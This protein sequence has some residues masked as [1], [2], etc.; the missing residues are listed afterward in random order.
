MEVVVGLEQHV[1]EL[2]V[3]DALLGALE[4]GL[5]GLLGDHLV[6]GE[7]L[8][9]VAEEVDEAVAAEPLGVVEQQALGLA[10]RRRQVEEAA[11]AGPG[12][13]R[14]WP[15]S[16]SAESRGRSS[17]LPP[18]SPIRP[19][20]A[21][22]EQDR[23]MAG[24]LQ[25]AQGEDA[26]QVAD[27]QAVG[28][29][30]EAGVGGRRPGVEQRP[31]RFVAHLV[32]EAAKREILR[33][34]RHLKA[35]HGHGSATSGRADGSTR[36]RGRLRPRARLW[37]ATFAF[38]S[39]R[40]TTTA[41]PRLAGMGERRVELRREPR[42]RTPTSIVSHPA[43]RAR[44]AT[45]TV[46]GVPKSLSKLASSSSE[47]CGRNE[48]MPPPPLSSTTSTAG[49]VGLPPARARARS[50]RAGRRGRRAGRR[51]GRPCPAAAAAT[52]SVVE[53]TPSI[54]LAPRF[55]STRG[56]SEPWR[57]EPL[58]VAHRHRGRG[59]DRSSPG[60][61]Q[62]N[63]A[64]ATPG[65][66]ASRWRAS[67]P[68]IACWA[69]ASASAH[70]GRP[71]R[72]APRQAERPRRRP[73]SGSRASMRASID[74]VRI[75]RHDDV[76][77][78][79]GVPPGP[80]GVDEHWYGPGR[81]A[82]G[83]PVRHHLRR[84]GLAEAQDDLGHV[85]AREAARRARGRRRR[86]R[87]GAPALA[88]DPRSRPRVGEDR[89]AERWR[90]GA[91]RSRDV[92]APAPAT[93]TPFGR[94][95]GEADE[96][97]ERPG[98]RHPADGVDPV[99]RPAVAAA[100]RQVA[101]LRRARGLPKREVGVHRTRAHRPGDRLGDEPAARATASSTGPRSSGTPGSTA[102]RSAPPNRPACS[103][104]CGAPT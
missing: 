12:S 55:A 59:D 44:S 39:V 3:G 81:G 75:G 19:G 9:D 7:V 92:P 30:V 1:A 63:S 49:T 90:R 10:R 77:L 6:D 102:Q 36:G 69:A 99:P 68:S 74:M 64:R 31:E 80:V 29:R 25:P 13:P 15:A 50:S 57:R 87:V 101:R 95:A 65:S 66:V 32:D 60:G 43:A 94:G 42:A 98:L 48:K 14:G 61:D 104:V 96:G 89:P 97:V 23:A 33:E 84:P 24:E 8:A 34:G 16:C 82:R 18:G 78:A 17:D 40:T 20:A 100:R 85:L 71:A 67:A 51:P 38:R 93:I 11:R 72:R 86:R 47:A 54:P 79:A 22:G 26:E 27:M 2:G 21:A 58:E 28:G 103:T 88:G 70:P 91:G 45:S 5:D 52:P 37:R 41:G 83:Q 46:C 35:C 53:A 76:G 62:A 56:G 4:A 73:P